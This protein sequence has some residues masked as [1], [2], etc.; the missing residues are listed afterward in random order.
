MKHDN[1][2]LRVLHVIPAVGPAYGGPSQAVVQMCDAVNRLGGPVRAEVL[3]TDAASPNGDRLDVPVGRPVVAGTDNATRVRHFPYVGPESFKFSPGLGGWLRRHVRRYA[4]VHVHGLFGYPG[5]AAARACRRRGVPYVVRPLGMLDPWSLQQ[6][7]VRKRVALALAE[8]ANLRGAAGLHFTSEAER[9]HAE[10]VLG[11]AAMREAFVS[12]I[13][14][15]G[16]TR[17]R[18]PVQ[19][20]FRRRYPQLAGQRIVLFMGRVHPKKGIELILQ[21]V[22]GLR[23]GGTRNVALVIAGEGAE[24]YTAKL[25][26]TV[27][28]LGLGPHVLWT[29]WLS[30]ETKREALAEADVFVLP[31]QQENFGIAA[32]EAMAAGVPVIVSRAVGLWQQVR[33]HEAG[34]VVARDRAALVEA[35]GLLLNDGGLRGRLG[36]NARR[37]AHEAYGWPAIAAS[38]VQRY[39]QLAQSA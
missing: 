12:P 20:R 21:S 15:D 1:D 39:S 28:R 8:R 32:V 5:L 34:L 23:A 26:M 3:T 2:T 14:V 35:L 36:A 19:G 25:A 30:G 38:L 10:G 22:A 11:R 13:G 4:V 31:S 16:H 7:R 27:D 24:S 18:L 6:H 29:G 37:L 17:D 33:R 9:R